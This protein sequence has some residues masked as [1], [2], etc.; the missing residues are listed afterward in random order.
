M[1]FT[2]NTVSGVLG[3]VQS[4]EAALGIPLS[5]AASGPQTHEILLEINYDIHVTRGINIQPE[6]QYV[7]RPNAQASIH[8]AAV[9]GFKRHVEF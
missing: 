7:F 4:R 2:Y 8:D 3:K 5:N 1:L 6:F 9:F